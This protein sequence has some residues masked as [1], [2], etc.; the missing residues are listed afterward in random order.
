MPIS[1]NET[2]YSIGANGEEIICIQ[3]SRRGYFQSTGEHSLEFV[4]PVM[5]LQVFLAFFVSRLLY[6]VLRPLKQPK[7]VCNVLGGIILGPSVLSHNHAIRERCFPPREMVVLN[8]V[9]LLGAMYS[10]FLIAV[11]MDTS[12]I[13]RTARN[14]W[15]IGLTGMV[16]PFFTVLFLIYSLP[17]LNNNV[18]PE[19][20]KATGFPMFIAASLSLSFFPVVANAL[21]ELNLI[22]TELGLLA[23][24]SALVN[25][26]M[27]WFLV[28][29]SV[30]VLNNDVLQAVGA[31]AAFFAL[32]IFTIS[33]VRPAIV[34]IIK[35]T[36]QGKE[37]PE[38]YIV[39]TLVGVL[40]MGFIT[41]FI[42]TSIIY[43]G[44]I[45]GFVIPD[46]PPLGSIL[47]EKSELL[48]SEFFLP[49]FFVRVGYEMNVHAIQI[50][51]PL[52]LLGASFLLHTL[53]SL[54]G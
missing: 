41:D 28:L 54:W 13:L 18:L 26:V 23:L 40:A 2:I 48:V 5:M 25:D 12:M 11:K 1:N 43:G 6:Y 17:S 20:R 39:L 45:L 35:K 27:E 33:V 29:L 52:S 22:T 32:V 53:P 9:S 24:S 16:L 8:T 19:A 49:L 10:V 30:I 3:D 46:G 38:V 21:E 34:L 14:A 36:P 15:S 44:L 31:L 4:L 47:V 50:G 7:I 37:V 42:G 51:V